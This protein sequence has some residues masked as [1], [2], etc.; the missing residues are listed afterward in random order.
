MADGESGRRRRW[1]A[2][3]LL[4]GAVIATC[5]PSPPPAPLPVLDDDARPAT[6]SA[7]EH[8]PASIDELRARVGEVLD[9]EGVPGVAIAL[10]GRD[11]PIWIGGVGVADLVTRAPVRADTVFRVASITKSIV[12]L[13][14]MRLVEAG[15]LDLDRPLR[16]VVPDA[17]IEN[18]WEA[19]APV[20]LAQVLEHTAGLDD[21]HFNEFFTDDETLPASAALAINPRARKVRWLPGTRHSYSNVGYTLAAR[22][23][24]VATG[25]PFDAWLRR[26]VLIPLGM[27]GADFQR[28]DALAARLATGYIDRG[29]AVAFRP[30]A[31]RGAGALL[32]S[33]SDLARLVQFFLRRS[34]AIVSSAGLDRIERTGT[35]SYGHLDLNY[36]LG[37][38]GDV[39]QPARGRGHDGGLPG[40]AS[41]YRYFP[42]LGVGYV[43]LLNA[44]HSPLAFLE[45]RE[46]V[47]SYLTRGKALR[48]PPLGARSAPE[49]EFFAFASPRNEL[50]AFIDRL[51]L[52]WRAVPTDNGVRLDSLL[53]GS[54]ELVP[55]ADGGFRLP[56]ES[57]SSVRFARNRDDRPVMI[58][59][60][61]YAEAGS[62]WWLARI[63]L[64]A[65]ELAVWLLLLAPIWTAGML[66]LAALRRRRPIAIDLAVWP[67][68]AGGC[69]IALP[70]LLFA[71]VERADL[72]AIGP[73]TI[74]IC[75]TTMVF[76]VAGAGG[77]IAV[78]RWSVRA[79]R[80]SAWSRIVPTAMAIAA[81]GLAWWLC[82]HGIIGLRTWAW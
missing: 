24:E 19:V 40:F 53:G 66:V 45:I 34:P 56:W 81:A 82:A 72:G 22:A 6:F 76:A 67:A 75:A 27:T 49:A 69:S 50:F 43:I 55:T 5:I 79:D 65:V 23:I 59:Q 8:A 80:P 29:R 9:R 63:R 47:F 1:L 37:N 58:A 17:G 14:V 60:L 26:A 44:T 32:A 74:A 25:E 16:D 64:A 13:G 54:F 62:W 36:G 11:G 20:T 28:T 4:V 51:L 78:G 52:G 31:H 39:S 33:A 46:L 70:W 7:P 38:Y 21:M 18:P 3:G 10:V 68:V 48:E 12:A 2:C 42:E 73:W 35:L 57:G 30:I 41:S 71:A 15:R 61:A 77:L